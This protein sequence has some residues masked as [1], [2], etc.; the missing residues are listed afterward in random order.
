MET[1][2]EYGYAGDT[3][4][5]RDVRTFAGYDVVYCTC[6][7]LSELDS[8]LASTYIDKTSLSVYLVD[9]VRTI[10]SN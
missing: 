7:N 5:S 6:C 1:L 4:P 3:Q 10:F 2:R 9:E 8:N